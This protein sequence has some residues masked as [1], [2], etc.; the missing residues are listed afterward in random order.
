MSVW[1]PTF[2]IP[3]ALLCVI[4][5]MAFAWF[6]QHRAVWRYTSLDELSAL[7]KSA[8]LTLLLFLPFLFFLSRGAELTR[9][10]LVLTW[11]FLI[12]F[13]VTP[14]LIAR[15]LFR[16]SVKNLSRD[17]NTGAKILSLVYGVGP[18]AQGFVAAMAK[19]PQAV[20][21]VLGFMAPDHSQRGS[22]R[23][24]AE[25]HALP[26]Y[27]GGPEELAIVVRQL[28]A[29]NIVV[30]RVI[31]TEPVSQDHLNAILEVAAEAGLILGRLPDDP[32]AVR[33][34][35]DTAVLP[36]EVEDLI[37]PRKRDLIGSDQRNF[38]KGK[39]V[40]I[41]GAGGSIGAEIVRQ[42]A[43]CEPARLA[44]LEKSEFALYTIDHELTD[45]LRL[46]V[47]ETILCDV[48]D[49][50]AVERWFAIV[51]PE[52]VF[53]AAG[54]K[55]VPMIEAHPLEGILTN[56][57]G[58]RAVADAAQRYG[59]QIMVL[60]SSDKAVNPTSVMGATK[61]LAEA[62]CQALDL[63]AAPA[64]ERQTRF[65]TVRFGNVLWSNG[66][67]VSLFRRQ[68]AAG[69]PLTVTH[70]DVS[71]YF[72]TI[73]EAAQ[74]ILKA[75]WIVASGSLVR[76]GIVVMEMGE[77]IRIAALARQMIRLGGRRPDVDVKIQYMGLRPGEKLNEELLHPEEERT[78]LGETGLHL[79]CPRAAD[80]HLLRR[81]ID[82]LIAFARKGDTQGA[83]AALRHCVPEYEPAA[84]EQRG[85]TRTGDSRE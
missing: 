58:T 48:R 51:R 85:R 76:G 35:A 66:S 26:V 80:L 67:V 30:R 60:V 83:I 59:A 55:H 33:E 16:R 14:R 64:G 5:S 36:V 12:G 65:A 45:A 81:D 27:G 79:A 15:L 69:G 37:V 40:L 42:V 25:A 78:P 44:L 46:P 68:L 84:P 74:L 52:I 7:L 6:N 23:A 57:E 9:S 10:S 34:G 31:L 71:R 53:H 61:R 22:W 19:D 54:L 38:L 3:T 13:L 77:Q 72:M 47:H 11:M 49:R 24:V 41:T 17:A 82:A 32:G 50:A 39:R 1:Y 62:Y 63:R 18:R 73:R 29:E 70:P 4:A 21:R 43:A 2:A 8:S 56:V 75:S 20:Y 28:R